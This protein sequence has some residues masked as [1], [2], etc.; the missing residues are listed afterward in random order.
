MFDKFLGL[1]EQLAN[2]PTTQ[3]MQKFG[4]FDGATELGEAEAREIDGRSSTRH[5]SSAMRS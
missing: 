5:I 3:V 4:P 2:T 1:L